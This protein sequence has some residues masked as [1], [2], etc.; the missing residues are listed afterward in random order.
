MMYVAT[1]EV[2]FETPCDPADALHHILRKIQWPTVGT[3]DHG[4][5]Y[6]EHYH[7]LGEPKEID[8]ATEPDK[9]EG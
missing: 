4:G 5:G 2:E 7:L 6:V 8:A 3:R 1:I 9:E